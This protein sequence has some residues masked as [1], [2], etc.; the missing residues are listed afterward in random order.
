MPRTGALA[1]LL[2]LSL[3]ACAR[4]PGPEASYRSLAKAVAERD[5]DKAWSLLSRDSQKRL[6]ALAR[7]AAAR[8]PGVVPPSGRQ[9]LL[10]DAALGSRPLVRV[11]VSSQ[12]DERAVL[13]VEEQGSPPRQV[14]MVR[15]GGAW[16]VELPPP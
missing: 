1:L 12:Q 16:R 10:G 3:A 13:R 11:E 15:E 8:A 14:S 6:D 4:D 9:I 2:S 7:E 5:A